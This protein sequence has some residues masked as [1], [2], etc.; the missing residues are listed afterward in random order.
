[1]TPPLRWQS[2]DPA[3]TRQCGCLLGRL[4]RAGDVVALSGALGAGKTQFVKGLAAGLDV[5]ADEV[6]SSPTFVLMREYAGRLRLYHLDAYR[7]HDVDELLALGWEELL[8]EPG[9]VVVLEWADRV[10]DAVPPA[11]WRIELEH[12]SELGRLLTISGP[13]PEML[14]QLAAHLP[15]RSGRVDA[16][17]NAEKPAADG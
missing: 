1:V 4:L 14:G 5:R 3:R 15:G 10:P 13:N 7:L 17:G 8:E 6:V 12:L 11:A 9:A 2:D 16:A